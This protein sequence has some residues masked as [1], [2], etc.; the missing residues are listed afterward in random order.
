ML[1]CGCNIWFFSGTVDSTYPIRGQNTSLAVS[2]SPWPHYNWINGTNAPLW[3]IF[4]SPGRYASLWLQ[5]MIFLRNSGFYI[6]YTQTE[7]FLKVPL[8]PWLHYNWINGT[9][10]PL[11]VI[12]NFMRCPAQHSC[13]MYRSMWRHFISAPDLVSRVQVDCTLHNIWRRVLFPQIR[14]LSSF[15]QL[16]M[17]IFTRFNTE[18][19][20]RLPSGFWESMRSSDSYISLLKYS[21][22]FNHR[23]LFYKFYLVFITFSLFPTF[24][25][26]LKFPLCF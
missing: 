12:F 15:F 23:F 7:H 16:V 17:G 20:S 9:N 22:M 1:L 14:E 3:V 2:L 24:V 6:S 18:I 4:N 13:H 5:Y 10:V 26:Y 19:S 11:W 8:S 25:F 21:P